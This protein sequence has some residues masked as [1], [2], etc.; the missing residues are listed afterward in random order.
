MR[1]TS[2]DLLVGIDAGTSVIKSI[3]FDLK[4]EQ[5][6]VAALPNRYDTIPGGGAEQ[7]LA[8]TWADAA[9]TLRQLADKVPN[10]ARRIA[11][12]SVTGQGDGT[13][14]IDKAGEPVGK[15]WL[16][17]DAR[18][19][20]IVEDIRARPDDRP[21]F[22]KTGS[23]LAA[24]QQGPQ[25][26]HMQRT[27]PERVSAAATAFH[28]KDWLYF[29]LT[30][31]RA[32][33]P[34]E[35]CFS[36]GDF[37]ARAY[38]DDVIDVLGLKHLR[39]L[40]P[41]IVDGVAQ[42]T[43]LSAEAAAASGLLAGTPVVLG[44]VDV[45][46]TALGAGLYDPVAKPGCSIIGSTGMHMRLASS[47]DDVWLN[48][49]KTGYTMCM[50]TPGFYAQMQSNMAAT[51]NIDWVLGLAAGILA[52]QGI[53]RTSAEMIPLIDEWIST[54]APASLL[55]QPYVSEAGERGPFVD[56]NARAGFT[57]ISVRHGY[58]DLVRAV[59]EGLA[60][61][62]RDCYTA[63]GLLPAEVR[64]TGGAARSTALRRILGAA[65][66]AKVRTSSREEA[67]AAG[68]AMIAAVSIGQ[69][70]SMDDCAA[71]WVAPLLGS[72]E[73]HDKALSTVYEETYPAY[74]QTWQALRPVWKT[75]AASRGK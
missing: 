30:G 13:W 51:L 50:P 18:A 19:A 46:C 20:A 70:A 68:A 69:Y 74:V 21:R 17:L 57:G 63:M 10:L 5:I 33:D 36:F 42:S 39:R 29:R 49:S 11:A 72:G 56:A 60:F 58:G 73:V 28:C 3:A 15:G 4:G 47:A 22:E 54:S 41:P 24:C 61:A 8:R 55:Y 7:D 34:S 31:E 65:L 12:I 6:A 59:F 38:S 75:M 23:G 37:R 53:S 52:S 40:M 2:P 27:T 32:T 43:G 25:L 48:D 44:Y 64:L 1:M 71:E 66:G 67:G 26:I 16:W 14:L 9:T 62:S 35:G 45:V